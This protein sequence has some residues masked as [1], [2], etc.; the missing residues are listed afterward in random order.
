MPAAAVALAACGAPEPVRVDPPRPEGDAV[1][2]CRALAAELPDRVE[3]ADRRDTAGESSD[4]AAWGDPPIVLRCGVERPKLL[5]PGDESYNPMSDAV[6]VNGVSWLLEQDADGYRFTTV[7]R[8]V[9]LEVL[10]PGAYA[11]EIDVLV[12]LAEAV[13]AHLPFDPLWEDFY[14]DA[15]DAA[16]G[17]PGGDGDGEREDGHGEHEGH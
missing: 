13:D 15:G 7:E 9:H 6:Q 16:D 1:A 4:V 3:G 8:T 11:P 12:D 17:A 5:T 14:G 10:V 2:A